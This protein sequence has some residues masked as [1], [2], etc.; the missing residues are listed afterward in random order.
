MT[1]KKTDTVLTTIDEKTGEIMQSEH[2][3]SAEM[4]IQAT[5]ILAKK[6]P[7]N[8][9]RSFEKLTISCQRLTFAEE[10]EYSFPRGSKT[11]T[12]PSVNLA[13][14]A[15]RVWGNIRYG[16]KI[17]QDSDDEVTIEGW[18]WDIET[19]VK[20]ASQ[21]SFAKL[22]QRRNKTSG[23]TEWVTPDERDLR[24]L[25][26]RR[27][28]ISI[29]NSILQLLPRDLIEDAQKA[30]QK[31]RKAG[32]KQMSAEEL[33]KLWITAFSGLKPFG[34]SVEML[35]KFL[36]HPLKECSVEE[37]DRL[38]LIYN[39]INDGNSTWKEYAGENGGEKKETV[40]GN[41]DPDDLK[42]KPEGPPSIKRKEG[43]RPKKTVSVEDAI[44]EAGQ[45]TTIKGLEAVVKKHLE[46]VTTS[47][48]F[49]MAVN[50]IRAN[51]ESAAEPE[52]TKETPSDGRQNGMFDQ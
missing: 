18:A 3:A 9:E 44:T 42:T 41:L 11:I 34:V 22:H 48:D 31:T 38:K 1:T 13:R 6:F 16:L 17:V 12:G 23:I 47:E 4:E 30:C 25:I 52:T 39:S 19:N 46:L 49:R 45:Q 40:R 33:M 21:D 14:E 37:W 32:T 8:E 43:E 20:V 10:A 28:A 2:I 24:E 51:I 50:N 27:G 5:I 35:E 26:N 7:R 36:G 15:A 29:R